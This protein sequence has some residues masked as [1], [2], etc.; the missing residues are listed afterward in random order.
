MVEIIR[1]VV[2]SSQ[3]IAFFGAFLV[4]GLGWLLPIKTLVWGSF[5][6]EIL[7]FIA[8]AVLALMFLPRSLRLSLPVASIFMVS[9]IPVIQIF[10]G[11]L[12]FAGDGWLKGLYLVGFF[13]SV[14]IG[15]NLG[16][17]DKDSEKFVDAFAVVLV[18]ASMLS[19]LIGIRQWLGLAGSSVEL[20][21]SGA[22]AYANLG[23]PNHLATLLCCGLIA[24]VYLFERGKFGRI[25]ATLLASIMLFALVITQSRTP[26]LIG[27]SSVIFWWWQRR[28]LPLQVTSM[29]MVGWFC[30][31]ITMY[32]V[33]PLLSDALTLS[34]QSLE[35]RA[36]ASARLD[37]WAVAW[38]AITGAPALGYGWGQVIVAQIVVNGE[39]PLP[40]LM[41]YSHNLFLDILLWNGV[42]VGG[43]IISGVVI[44]AFRLLQAPP[45]L[46]T[47]FSLLIVGAVFTH[48]MFEYPY[49]YAFFLL[50]TGLMLGVA[51][52][53]RTRGSSFSVSGWVRA[54]LGVIAISILVI[55][56][57]ECQHYADNNINRRFAD[58]GIVGF[59]QQELKGDFRIFSHLE[60]L[61]HFRQMELTANLPGAELEK[62]S[63]VALRFPQVTVLYRYSLALF[64]NGRFDEGMAQLN[65]MRSIHGEEHYHASLEQLDGALKDAGQIG[66]PREVGLR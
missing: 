10:T 44:W 5:Y 56:V 17:G 45:R 22:R 34:S 2:S 6:P 43:L 26:F 38:K 15:F 19:A 36:D 8:I 28:R 25:T 21:H 65:L 60:A 31:F 12:I 18:V 42:W 63:L 9:L 1:S 49:A 66:L 41:F 50:P 11:T 64:L 48:A 58:A 16:S 62:M 3:R 39:L 14:V 57:R 23:Q 37:L 7:V 40:G 33:F 29:C 27:L 13:L 30:V 4:L 52:S 32:A 54:L 24:L 55:I 53:G 35:S 59:E 47:T 51:E 46:K 20:H 61:Q